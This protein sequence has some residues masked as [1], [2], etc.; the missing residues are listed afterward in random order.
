MEEKVLQ[1]PGGGNG[2][3]IRIVVLV[4]AVFL[5]LG[6]FVFK[7]NRFS[8]CIEPVEPWATT[9]EYGDAYTEPGVRVLVKGSLLLRRGYE[10]ANPQLTSEGTVEEELGEYTICYSAQYLWLSAQTEHTVTV[11]DTAPPEI[12]LVADPYYEHRVGKPY[13]EEGY[14]ATD[15]HDGDLTESV[16][17]VELYERIVYTVTDSSGN[18]TSVERV[19]PPYDPLP[20]TILLEGD[21]TIL[22]QLGRPYEEP[23]YLAVDNVDGELTESVIVEGEV[24]CFAAGI[25]PIRY[26]VKD[27]HGNWGFEV[28]TVEVIKEPRPQVNTPEGK[29]IY[30]TF[31]DGPGPYTDELLYVLDVYGVKATFFVTDSGYDDV[32]KRI[33][34]EGHSI[35]IH[36]VN[37]DYNEIYSS[38]QAYFADLYAMQ[39]IIY[40]N[41]GVR[42]TLLR[43]PGG[44]SNL[45]SRGLSRGLMTKLTKAV[46]DAGFQYFDWNVDSNDAGGAISKEVV[47]GNVIGGVMNERVS[48]V[49]Q[50]DIHDYSVNAVEDI[51]LWGLGNGY[52]F[53]PLQAD[54]PGCHHPVY[55]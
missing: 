12:T 18:E 25:Y 49:L 4:L 9:V 38:P 13:K 32:M 21:K 36:T 30:L 50:H 22:H 7:V 16:Q 31:D 40:E 5:A 43:F 10:L 20:P 35:G 6:L 39:D 8:L 55:N 41:T 14:K 37:H 3:W 26:T 29:V 42:T 52:T 44:S 51:I 48:I 2:K 15:N 46:Q 1:T 47:A 34:E 54:S 24:D 11:V 19:I 28:R 17:R 45:V 33:V 23:G 53:L 27:E